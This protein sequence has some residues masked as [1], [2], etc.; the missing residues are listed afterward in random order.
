MHI[1]DIFTGYVD[2]A[3]ISTKRHLWCDS[4]VLQQSLNKRHGCGCGL[5]AGLDGMALAFKVAEW[6]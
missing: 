4:L 1:I 5:L 3:G 2:G 6:Q